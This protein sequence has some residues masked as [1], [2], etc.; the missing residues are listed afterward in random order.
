MF[1]LE[2][3]EPHYVSSDADSIRFRGGPFRFVWNWNILVP[4]SYG[5]ITFSVDSYHVLMRYHV[6][7]V[8]L[9]PVTLICCGIL[10]LV[11]SPTAALVFLVANITASH[12]STWLR[13]PVLL[14]DA[15]EHALHLQQVREVA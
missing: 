1:A 10:C 8:E 13:F 4:I 14:R 5:R 9:L 6:S 2:D 11:G 12:L 7:F 15:A 3:A